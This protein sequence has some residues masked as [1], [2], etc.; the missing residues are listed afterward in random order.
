MKPSEEEY[1]VAKL[2]SMDLVLKALL[3]QTT[4]EQA[5]NALDFI[6]GMGSQ[7]ESVSEDKR[8]TLVVTGHMKKILAEYESI[9]ARIQQ[10]K[11]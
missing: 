9:L 2:Y 8:R 4:P 6:S 1:I 3:L 11:T 7:F 5:A 10:P